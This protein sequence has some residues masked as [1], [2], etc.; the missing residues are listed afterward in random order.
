MCG[1]CLTQAAYPVKHPVGFRSCLIYDRR[2]EINVPALIH[3]RG[4]CHDSI[5]YFISNTCSRA[6]QL[7]IE[8]ERQS[9]YKPVAEHYNKAIEQCIIAFKTQR[10]AGTVR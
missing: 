4:L 8:R 10:V 6:F 5:F 2:A 1:A 9:T 3:G 7:V